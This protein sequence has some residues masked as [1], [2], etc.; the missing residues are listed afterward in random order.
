MENALLPDSY[1]F[2]VP[3]L[4]YK[5]VGERIHH[6]SIAVRCYRVF[7]Y[8]IL[9]VLL[10]FTSMSF[11][12]EK[13]N[14]IESI[15]GVCTVGHPWLKYV[16]FIYNKPR[17]EQLLRDRSEIVWDRTKF[18][19]SFLMMDAAL[20]KRV[21]TVQI[22]LPSLTCV[23][24]LVY[25]LRPLFH[26]NVY[27]MATWDVP[28]IVINTMIEAL[29]YYLFLMLTVF[30]V[31]Y[32]C[33]YMGFC[34]HL[35]AQLRRLN[36]TLEHLA[37]VGIP[38]QN[39]EE[40]LKYLIRYHRLLLINFQRLQ[41]MFSLPLLFH[42]FV[43]LLSNCIELYQFM[44]NNSEHD[45]EQ[46]TVIL[47]IIIQFALYTFP[48]EAISSE[49]LNV[50]HSV[51]K[52]DWYEGSL[53]FQKLVLFSMLNAQ[54]S[55]CFSGGGLIPINVDAFGSRE[56][57]LFVDVQSPANTSS[58]RLLTTENALLRDSCLF[59]VPLALY[60]FAGEEMHCAS[61]LV[62]CCRVF[63]YA[64]STVLFVLVLVSFLEEEMNFVKSIDSVINANHPFLKYVPFIYNKPRLEQLLRNGSEIVWDSTKFKKCFIMMDASQQQR[65]RIVRIRF[66]SCTRVMCLVYMLRLSFH[67][68]VYIIATRDVPSLIINTIVEAFE[69][70]LFMML[71]VFI[72]GYDSLYLG[73]CR[74]LLTQLKRLNYSLKHL[75]IV[76]RFS[77]DTVKELRH[78]VRYHNRLLINNSKHQLEPITAIVEVII[79]FALYTFPAEAISSEFLNVSHSVY[80]SEWHE[81]S[82]EFQKLALFVML[83]AQVEVCFSGGGIIPINVDAFGSVIR[84][85]FSFYTVLSNMLEN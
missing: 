16:L 66:L 51:Y 12:Q 18:T 49:F 63:N 58:S 53:K 13:K 3:F 5:F 44:G 60:K 1:M 7:N 32:D 46:I 33:L 14:I 34:C 40:E 23:M 68:N 2:E 73:F 57:N 26:D 29:E 61:I 67:D 50:S 82:V 54:A 77:E 8:V 45:L 76:G 15:E 75:T 24:C 59:E 79:Q 78:L 17:V 19:K 37:I 70:Q 39:V 35:L 83:N 81:G 9:S 25:M 47:A 56:I 69:Y 64:I 38:S 22:L 4:L 62:Q 28:S 84:K 27:I 10:F 30:M 20:H 55:V 41:A 85:S 48:A 71:A 11:F 6:A 52:S 21:R 42:Y 43:S 72:I 36:Y 80:K 74:Y 65:V 31:S